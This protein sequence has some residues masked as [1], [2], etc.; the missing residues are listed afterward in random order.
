MRKNRFCTRT[1]EF[2]PPFP[3]LTYYTYVYLGSQLERKKKSM[4][5]IEEIKVSD[6]KYFLRFPFV[7]GVDKSNS[8]KC[9]PRAARETKKIE[10]RNHTSVIRNNAEVFC[11]GDE[12][13]TTEKLRLFSV[14]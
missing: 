11:I 6:H 9:V 3:F 2:D 5:K 7:Y 1:A 14:L 13:S 8:G 4:K 12:N 10:N